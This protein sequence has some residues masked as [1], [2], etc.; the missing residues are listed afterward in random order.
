MSVLQYF[1]LRDILAIRAIY[2]SSGMNIREIYERFTRKLTEIEFYQRTAVKTAQQ[3]L[4]AL[5]ITEQEREQSW[6]GIKNFP[7]S[8]HSMYYLHATTGKSAIF[9]GT[10]SGLEEMKRDVTIRRNKQYQWLLAEAYEELEDLFEH[11]YAYLGRLDRNAWPLADFGNTL[12]SELDDKDF[13]WYLKQAGHKKGAP[14]TI[15]NQLRKR[16]PELDRLEQHNALGIDFKFIIVF[17]QKLRHAIVHRGGVVR[18]LDTVIGEIFKA[19]GI[20]PK[21]AKTDAARQFIK[22]FFRQENSGSTIILI[23]PV[24][25]SSEGGGPAGSN[26]DILFGYI[27]S[28]GVLICETAGLPTMLSRPVNN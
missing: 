19:S 18:D 11:L 1:Q 28:Y 12:L 22:D 10:V 4:E 16:Y 21:G 24:A 13:S 6:V 2:F 25:S 7:V 9:G 8:A 3:E 5:L 17:I 27:V 23:E 20:P 26:L 14:E 15:L